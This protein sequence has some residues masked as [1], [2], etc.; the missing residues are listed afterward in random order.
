[1]RAKINAYKILTGNVEGKS[2]LV[3]LEAARINKLLKAYVCLCISTSQCVLCC[4]SNSHREERLFPCTNLPGGPGNVVG[5]ATAY[6][7][8]G[9]GIESRWG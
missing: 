6:G 9:P 3:K 8:D 5:I 1:M 4:R 2:S 7:L